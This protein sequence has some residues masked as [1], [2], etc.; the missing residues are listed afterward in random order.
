MLKLLFFGYYG[1]G[2]LGDDLLLK[3]L[4]TVFGDKYNLGVLTNRSDRKQQQ[5]GIREFYKFSTDVFKGVRWADV[6]VGGGGGIFQDKTSS[7][8]FYYYIFVLFLSLLF[9]KKVY[10]LGQSFS[11]LESKINE[12]L[13]R[14]FLNRI[15]KIYVRD[16]FSKEYLVKLGVKPE[17]I[18]LS[19]DLVFL[20]DFPF[21][22][23]NNSRAVGISLREWRGFKFEE[24]N[25]ILENL[26]QKY[27]EF[28]FF[29]FQDKDSQ[30]YELIENDFKSKIRLINPTDLEFLSYF[31]SCRLFIGMRLHSCILSVLLGIPF[32]AI[33][34]DEKVEAF[35]YEIDWKF[36]IKDFSQD[37]ILCYVNEIEEDYQY[38]RNYLLSK[39]ESLRKKIREDILDFEREICRL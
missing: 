4:I 29:S 14:V 19:A 17:K 23:K 26:T 27:G 31:S 11:P 32:I 39:R 9:G 16:S 7:R 5:K 37:K 33:S 18:V 8:S 34:Y 35:C 36:V 13:L 38:Y 6:V 30:I 3:S 15:E 20:L 24:F 21:E 12:V 10:L 1:E 28:Y 22:L 2:N 25:P